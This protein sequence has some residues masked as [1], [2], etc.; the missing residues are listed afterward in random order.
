LALTP[1]SLGSDG[2]QVAVEAVAQHRQRTSRRL[3]QLADG[4]DA[5]AAAGPSTRGAAHVPNGLSA[6]THVL[7]DESVVHGS[8]V[9]DQHGVSS[10]GVRGGSRGALVFYHF[11]NDI[12]Y[13]KKS[14]GF[15]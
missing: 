11:E 9:A 12:Q 1:S 3:E 2:V 14:N 15:A 5:A 4:G 7:F 10:F 8:A 6:R 13:H